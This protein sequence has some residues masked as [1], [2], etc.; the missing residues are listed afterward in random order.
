M[1]LGNLEV[2][3]WLAVINLSTFFQLLGSIQAG[4][5]KFLCIASSIWFR[6]M[7]A[8]SSNDTYWCSLCYRRKMP[9]EKVVLKPTNI[10]V[11]VAKCKSDPV[12]ILCWVRRQAEVLRSQR[13]VY[14]SPEGDI[15]RDYVRTFEAFEALR[16]VSVLEN[17][18]I[19]ISILASKWTSCV[20]DNGWT[21]KAKRFILGT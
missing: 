15:W 7:K 12:P 14:I 16:I 17:N 8:V 13:S 19:I 18:I 21:F 11:W 10:A 2:F 3:I 20:C 9:S 5:S 4:R 1:M 6:C